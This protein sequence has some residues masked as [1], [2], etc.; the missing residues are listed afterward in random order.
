[1][2]KSVKIFIN[3]NIIIIIF[4]LWNLKNQYHELCWVSE[5][6]FDRGDLKILIPSESSKKQLPL[7]Y[8][9]WTCRQRLS[10]GGGNKAKETKDKEEDPLENLI[11]FRLVVE[12]Q[13]QLFLSV[14]FTLS[15]PRSFDT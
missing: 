2:C 15:S 4:A 5:D 12:E 6:L 9:K 11:L 13:Q 1:M 7:K 14:A 3:E 10:P 8:P